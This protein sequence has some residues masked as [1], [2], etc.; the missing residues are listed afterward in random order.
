LNPPPM[1]IRKNSYLRPTRPRGCRAASTVWPAC[2]LLV[3]LLLPACAV[4]TPESARVATPV[5]PPATAALAKPVEATPAG[6]A[7]DM[8]P[9][10]E[11]HAVVVSPVNVSTAPATAIPQRPT[12]ITVLAYG[13]KIRNLSTPELQQ[14]IARLG[15]PADPNRQ[16]ADDLQLAMALGQTRVPGDLARAQSLL[17]RVLA[18]NQEEVRQLH[19][20]ARLLG[21][22]YA[23][24]KRV[25]D[26]LDRQNQQLR[27]SQRRIDQL[28]E[29]LEAMRAI[30]RSL[31]SRTPG[32]AANGG[33]LRPPP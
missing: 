21:A 1:P 5:G 12:N 22:R 11:T 2:S 16:P 4:Q 9:P 6:K 15:D 18:N 23:E 14:E 25:E 33:G 17:Q 27:D 3:A 30:E 10:L 20:L 28:N 24:Q 31:T 32:A 26:Q 8:P 19:P 7:A 13:D 29:R